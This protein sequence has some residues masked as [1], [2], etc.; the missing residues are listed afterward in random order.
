MREVSAI[1]V[2]KYVDI[3][4]FGSPWEPACLD[5]LR[6]LPLPLT[7]FAALVPCSRR[8]V[9]EEPLTSAVGPQTSSEVLPPLTMCS[10]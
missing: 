9:S 4:V 10:R 5:S 6:P 2:V 1:V 8:H 3:R 7:A